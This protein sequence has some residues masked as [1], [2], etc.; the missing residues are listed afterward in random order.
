MTV[1]RIGIDAGGSLIKLA[2]F[3]EEKLHVKTYSYHDLSSLIKWLSIIAPE[4]RICITGGKS[5]RVQEKLTLPAKVIDEFEATVEGAAFLL[6]QEAKQSVDRC[7]VVNVG[8]GTSLHLLTENSSERII[9]TGVGGGT[10]LGLAYLLS[11]EDDFREVVSL[12]EKGS[13]SEMDLQVKD[14]YAP[15]EPPIP[16]HFTASNFGKASGLSSAKKEDAIAALTGMIA[17]T[18]MLLAV[19]AA[20]IHQVKDIVYIGGTVAGNK[21][22]QLMLSD[23]TTAFG[24]Q[25]LFLEKGEYSGAIGALLFQ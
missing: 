7:I 15:L 1:K 23:A 19:Q 16:G 25:P 12:A 11:G 21:P 2:Y 17:Q 5:G 10:F 20:G 13:R 9:G 18:I 8:T 3:E 4:A 6:K 24:C 14:I 22:I